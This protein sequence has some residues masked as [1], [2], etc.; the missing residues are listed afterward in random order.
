MDAELGKV[1]VVAILSSSV[2]ASLINVFGNWISQ[3]LQEGRER[4]NRRRAFLRD[5][6]SRI[7]E[8][9]ADLMK[10]HIGTPSMRHAAH[11]ELM[12][13][14]NKNSQIWAD[15]WLI[16][17]KKLEEYFTGLRNTV[18]QLPLS[19]S[20]LCMDERHNPKATEV[21]ML[22]K[23]REEMGERFFSRLRALLLE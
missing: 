17:D 9:A 5:H 22:W 12:D 11:A 18:H 7:A 2:I 19:D 3:Q 16:G 23:K 6:T 15:L 10:I 21:K 13:K 4:A 1:V 14:W 20:E 8:C